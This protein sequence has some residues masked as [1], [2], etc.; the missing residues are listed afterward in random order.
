MQIV[1]YRRRGDLKI[2]ALGDD[3]KSYHFLNAENAINWMKANTTGNPT[4][5][6][7][8]PSSAAGAPAATPDTTVTLTGTNFTAQSE[9]LLNGAPFAKTFVSPTSMTILLKPSLVPALTVWNVA[10]R[11]GVYETAPKQFTF[12]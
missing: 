5:A 3:G 10:V 12:T 8:T 2:T 11:N 1:S 9:V 4:L 6:S 7:L